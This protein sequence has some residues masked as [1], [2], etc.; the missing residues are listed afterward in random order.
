MRCLAD[1]RVMGH[2]RVGDDEF[3]LRL[4]HPSQWH[5][6]KDRPQS[7]AFVTANVSAWMRG[8]LPGNSDCL[9]HIPPFEKH[10]RVALRA[11]DLRQLRRKNGV[12]CGIDV[13]VVPEDATQPFEHLREAH[14]EL[15]YRSKQA[16]AKVIVNYV[17]ENRDW[18]IER[19]PDLDPGQPSHLDS[20]PAGEAPAG[21]PSV[22]PNR[23]L[24]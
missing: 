3:A 12:N 10:G 13:A 4:V 20:K 9:L 5:W 14:A 18:A 19:R 1:A 21:E 17:E 22:P 6:R 24:A 23:Y 16:V 11:G 7:A 8:R 15:L 2:E